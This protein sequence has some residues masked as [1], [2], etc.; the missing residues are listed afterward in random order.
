MYDSLQPHGLQPTR[1]LC[2]WDF[3]GKSTGVECHAYTT[4][5][6]GGGVEVRVPRLSLMCLAGIRSPTSGP[7]GPQGGSPHQNFG[8]GCCVPRGWSVGILRPPHGRSGSP[9]LGWSPSPFF[10]SWSFAATALHPTPARQAPCA[11][12]GYPGGAV[13]KNQPANAGSCKRCKFDP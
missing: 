12:L 13:E 4:T 9:G 8:E 6:G 1:L 2:P 7:P 11:H 5:P 3:P 10:T